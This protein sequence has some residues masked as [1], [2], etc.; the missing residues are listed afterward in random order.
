MVGVVFNPVYNEMFSAARG[1]GAT[2]NGQALRVAHQPNLSRAV[3]STG[4]PYN[5]HSLADN[6]LAQWEAMLMQVRDLR[7][8]GS[9]AL[10][11]AFVAAGRLDGYW[12]KGVHSWDCLAGILLIREAGGTV[13]D[14]SG[15]T[16]RLYTG[17]EIVGSNGLIH[18]RVL[19]VLNG[20]KR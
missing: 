9:C 11:L 1:L 14:Y 16:E 10:D 15:G 5:R 2:L 20:A 3:L 4:F 7:R 6:N 13:T 19:A 18:E 12:E 8:F 17:A